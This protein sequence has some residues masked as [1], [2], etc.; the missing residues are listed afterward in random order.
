[1]THV[2]WSLVS[3]LASGLAASF[4]ATAL[5]GRIPEVVVML[6]FGIAIGPHALGL[7]SFG[8]EVDI[9]RELGLGMLFL[10]AGYEIDPNELRGRTGRRAT[11]TWLVC[12]ALAFALV[13]GLAAAGAV[14]AE[15]AVAIALTSTAIGTLLP[16]L[17]DNE[18][19]ETRL[20]RVVVSHGAIGEIGPVVAMSVL[21][22][23]RG[24]LAE[25]IALAGFV[26]AALVVWLVHRR[27]AASALGAVVARGLETTSQTPVRAV[28]VL[29]VLLLAVASSFDLDIILGAFAAGFILRTIA[30]DDAPVLESKLGAIGYGLLVPVFFVGAG[31]AID[32]RA[33]AAHPWLPLI[34]VGL[35][36][37]VRGL[38][39]FLVERSFAVRDRVRIA[40]FASTG[41]PIVVAVTQVAVAAGEMSGENAS[42]LVFGGAVTVLVLPSLALALGGRREVSPR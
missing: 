4:V 5:R 17:T 38:P 39:V 23:A 2:W 11:L 12:L 33:V 28:V 40:L 20:G 9:L 13:F 32:L 29:L 34:F 3:I 22:G 6:A 27:L 24:A 30:P 35:I 21:L 31:M 25:L 1:M 42:V 19:T 7:A 16:I 36:L 8:S 41:L 26:V 15:V 37:L 14:T 10:L 18:L